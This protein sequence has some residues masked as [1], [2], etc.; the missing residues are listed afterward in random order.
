[1]N[2]S[3]NSGSSKSDSSKQPANR[4]LPHLNQNFQ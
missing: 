1:M 4:Y 2:V 3:K